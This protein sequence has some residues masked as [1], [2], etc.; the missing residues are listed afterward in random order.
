[1]EYISA[2]KNEEHKDDTCDHD[3][4]ESLHKVSPF[5]G[6]FFRNDVNFSFCKITPSSWVTVSACFRQVIRVDH[7]F[8]VGGRTDIMETMTTGTVRYSRF[9]EPG[10]SSM[11]GVGI[12]F[13]PGCDEAVLAR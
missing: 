7:R 2:D 4:V 11:K 9:S 12:C 13:Q 3:D 10:G 8:G 1:M 5:I 6:R